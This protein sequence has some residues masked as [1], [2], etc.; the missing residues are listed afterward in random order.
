MHFI[1]SIIIF[2]IHRLLALT[3][4]VR[5][6]EPK[7]LLEKLSKKKP[8]VLAHWHGDEGVVILMLRRYKVATMISTSKDGAIMEGIVRL[9]G[10]A[11]ISRG[12]ATRGGSS[13]LKRMVRMARLGINPSLAVD[14]PKG[15]YHEIKPG[16]FEI[17][18]LC[19]ADIYAAGVACSRAWKFRKAWNQA[20]LPKPFAKIIIEWSEPLQF[21]QPDQDPKDPQLRERLK[22][23]FQVAHSMA[24]TKLF[25]RHKDPMLI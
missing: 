15:P 24:Q 4:R 13:G 3:W 23:S 1:L 10:A 25:A 9:Y 8:V 20:Y 21:I 19:N 22:T 5:I 11:A 17:S 14:G 12:S 18:K 6:V 2:C 7:A 16:V